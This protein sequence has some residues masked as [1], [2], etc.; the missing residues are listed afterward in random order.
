VVAWCSEVYCADSKPSVD[1]LNTG[2]G[3]IKWGTNIAHCPDMAL[4]KDAGNWK[5]HRIYVRKGDSPAFGNANLIMPICYVFYD[6][7]FSGMMGFAHGRENWTEFRNALFARYGEG[8]SQSKSSD[9]WIW[10]TEQVLMTLK[11][12]ARTTRTR[13]HIMYRPL[14]R[15]IMAEQSPD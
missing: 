13:L 9:E 10:E 15:E 5:G 12:D 8:R 4:V 3:G 6:S 14:A 7:R 11:Y 2:F 1:V